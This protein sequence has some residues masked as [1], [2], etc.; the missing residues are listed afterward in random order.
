MM[1]RLIVGV[2]FMVIYS[3]VANDSRAGP[4]LVSY[5]VSGTPGNYDLD[6]SV[7]NNMTAWHQNVYLLGVSLSGF[8]VASSPSPFFS[9]GATTLNFAFYGG[10]NTQYNTNWQADPT[11]MDLFPGNSLS[12]FVA[13]DTD[14]IAPTAVSWFAFSRDEVGFDN[15]PY[16]GGGNFN[17]A[18]SFSNPGFEGLATPAAA[19]VPEPSTF[20]L[21]C[22]LLCIL[23]IGW[24]CQ[25]LTPFM[26]KRF[27]CST[28]SA[29]SLY[30]R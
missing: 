30:G 7:T 4:V 3:A 15:E 17:G 2:A 26:P 16:T 19:S 28:S 1:K 23:T 25:W 22:V 29:H 10:S 24:V 9:L 13:H 20:V 12:G 18:F 21:T 8:D 14:L 11:Q 5:T 27:I 6:F